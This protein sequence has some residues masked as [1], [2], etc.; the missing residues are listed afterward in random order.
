MEDR[1]SDVSSQIEQLNKLAEKTDDDS[2]FRDSQL[3]RDA[4]PLVD[5][6]MK[7]TEERREE[8][9]N[10]T[11]IGDN[12]ADVVVFDEVGLSKKAIGLAFCVGIHPG[13]PELPDEWGLS[14]DKV[15]QHLNNSM[16]I[17]E[18]AQST[19]E[20]LDEVFEETA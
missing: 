17:F 3:R 13:N 1:T 5:Q 7:Q 14:P 6:I 12:D 8:L 10:N 16:M 19:V 15:D 4:K 20:H 11:G 9:K 18:S 2:W